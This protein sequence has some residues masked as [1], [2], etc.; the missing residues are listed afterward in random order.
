[1]A[2]KFLNW[3]KKWRR[4]QKQ[5]TSSHAVYFRSPNQSR[6]IV[7][8][9]AKSAHESFGRLEE[10]AEKVE[11]PHDHLKHMDTNRAM[12]ATYFV[13]AFVRLAFTI[14]IGIPFYNLLAAYVHAQPLDINQL[15]AQAGALLGGPLGFVVGYY[16]KDDT[17]ARQ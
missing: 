5:P 15:L 17:A 3:F 11:S 9:H 8:G 4:K 13:K 1:M 12:I 16:F 10:S 2:L 6:I 7:T 14:L